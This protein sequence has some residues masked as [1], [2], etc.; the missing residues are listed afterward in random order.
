MSFIDDDGQLYYAPENLLSS[1]TENSDTTGKIEENKLFLL[2]LFIINSHFS[3]TLWGARG[4]VYNL[5]EWGG[6][7]VEGFG[8]FLE[9]DFRMNSTKKHGLKRLDF[10]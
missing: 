4:M 10:A 8:I 3:K 6:G 9:K 7:W 5:K 2:E 1:T